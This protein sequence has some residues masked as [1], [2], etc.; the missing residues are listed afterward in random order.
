[1]FRDVQAFEELRSLVEDKEEIESHWCSFDFLPRPM[2]TR[3]YFDHWVIKMLIFLRA[4]ELIQYES[5][6][7]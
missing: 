6:N 3:K 1:M 4:K 5:N 7:I 2:F